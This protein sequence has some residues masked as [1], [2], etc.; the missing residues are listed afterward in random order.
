MSALGIYA[1]PMPL[2]WHSWMVIK[3]LIV[4]TSWICAYFA[5]KH[6]PIS[7][8]SP[9]RA[10]GPVWTLV[11]AI[12]IFNERPEPLQW[13]G[14][15]LIFFCY[16]LFSLLGREEGIHFHRSKWVGLIFAATVIGTCSTLF[17]KWLLQVQ[18]MTPVQVLAWYFIY[19]SVFFTLVNGVLWWPNRK[20][21]TPFVWRWSIPW[22]GVLL[23]IAD[24]VYFIGVSDPDALI[25]ILSVLR[26]CSVL[27]SFFVGAVLFREVNKRKKAWVLLGL[28]V[29]VLFILFSGR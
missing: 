28:M 4:G 10:S 17:D 29:G 18:G 22:I 3:A 15:G 6:L 9:I 11:G 13:A 24:W 19:L 2:E 12:L 27:V 20:K 25:I 16:F 7:I 23:A 1:A 14:M 8:V 26:R 5:L 21:T